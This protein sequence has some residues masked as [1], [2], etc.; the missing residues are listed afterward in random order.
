MT[1]PHL[2]PSPLEPA[3]S[4]TQQDPA[5]APAAPGGQRVSRRTALAIAAGLAGL[6]GLG[7]LGDT[8][9][10]LPLGASSLD[11]AIHVAGLYRIRLTLAPTPPVAGRLM[12]LT[13]A[14][15]D[16]TGQPMDGAH[17]RFALAMAAMDMGTTTLTARP[18]G[19]G[20]YTSA[21]VFPMSGAWNVGVTIDAPGQP[22]ATTTFVVGVR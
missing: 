16:A 10:G 7:W 18:S 1:E 14:V 2:P 6:L 22:A 9:A 19:N 17:A 12:S 13:L 11:R 3:D 5:P 4:R 8:L 20:R 21:T 15:T